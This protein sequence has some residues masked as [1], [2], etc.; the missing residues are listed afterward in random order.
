MRLVS[1]AT[2]KVV[3]VWCITHQMDIE[4]R[5]G[6]EELVGGRWVMSIYILSVYLRAQLHLITEMGVQ[7]PKKTN[8]WVHLGLVIDFLIKYKIRTVRYIAENN[9]APRGSHAAIL[10]VLTPTMWIIAHGV[11]QDIR[12]TSITFVE[13]KDRSLLICQQRQHMAK[14]VADLVVEFGVKSL[15]I[16]TEYRDLAP[17]DYY[18]AEDRWIRNSAIVQHIEDQGSLAQLHYDAL[19]NDEDV[20]GSQVY[21]VRSIVRFV[22]PIVTGMTKLQAERDGNNAAYEDE[23]P[24]VMPAEIVKLRPTIVE[25]D[26]L[27]S[28]RV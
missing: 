2:N 1:Q 27:Q 14:L 26:L 24:P 19:E 16:D 13:L 3:R 23:A 22:C 20:D 5:G 10:P 12:R 18:I 21:A 9:A 28:Y 6:R 15:Q 4:V 7:C 11:A 17:R 25:N 8:R